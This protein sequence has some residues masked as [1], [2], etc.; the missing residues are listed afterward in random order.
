[1]DRLFVGGYILHVKLCTGCSLTSSQENFPKIEKDR[2]TTECQSV[3][4]KAYSFDLH[5]VS[6]D[7]LILSFSLYVCTQYF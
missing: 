3:K 7:Q 2:P 5:A 1:M 6:L 4:I